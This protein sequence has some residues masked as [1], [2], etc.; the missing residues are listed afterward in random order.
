MISDIGCTLGRLDKALTMDRNY[1]RS[2]VPRVGIFHSFLVRL[3]MAGLLTVPTAGMVGCR[4]HVVEPESTEFTERDAFEKYGDMYW[5]LMNGESPSNK[6]AI[7]IMKRI[8]YSDPE[9]FKKWEKLSKTQLYK[10]EM[11]VVFNYIS[12][13]EDHPEYKQTS[14]KS[15]QEW[16]FDGLMDRYLDKWLPDL[17][18]DEVPAQDC[19]PPPMTPKRQQISDEL[20]QILPEIANDKVWETFPVNAKYIEDKNKIDNIPYVFSHNCNNPTTIFTHRYSATQK[21]N[22]KKTTI[23]E[24]LAHKTFGLNEP[25]ACYFEEIIFRNKN[26]LRDNLTGSRSMDYE[27]RFI[28]ALLEMGMPQ[29]EFHDALVTS[30]AAIDKIC[31]EWLAKIKVDGKPFCTMKDIRQI[32]GLAD[33]SAGYHPQNGSY[34]KI[35][36]NDAQEFMRIGCRMAD[37]EISQRQALNAFELIMGTHDGYYIDPVDRPPSNTREEHIKFFHDYV[38]LNNQICEKYGIR[39]MDYRLYDNGRK[40][41]NE[42]ETKALIESLYQK[43]L[44]QGLITDATYIWQEKVGKLNKNLVTAN[45]L[46]SGASLQLV[47]FV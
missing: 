29:K 27:P 39:P 4:K 44:S 36:N 24:A 46:S 41:I 45:G 3:T 25:L 18:G 38:T 33:C 32:Q 5:G 7:D 42:A 21:Q 31:D 2:M 20:K 47:P 34:K 37:I 16:H 6:E 43:A 22:I 30:N 13:L 19:D 14:N 9:F 10:D 23:H 35:N 26:P 12:E 17:N 40:V 28:W 11:R 8:Y 1:K 15:S